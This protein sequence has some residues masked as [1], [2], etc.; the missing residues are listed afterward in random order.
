M[1]FPLN[2][3]LPYIAPPQV[4]QMALKLNYSTLKYTNKLVDIKVILIFLSLMCM[5][6]DLLDLSL[7]FTTDLESYHLRYN[8]RRLGRGKVLCVFNIL[9]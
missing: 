7:Y 8:H 4:S 3:R 5:G 9:K 1:D 6:T 2:W